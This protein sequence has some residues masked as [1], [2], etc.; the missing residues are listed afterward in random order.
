MRDE[1]IAILTKYF[2]ELTQHQQEQ[3]T[4]LN[5]LYRSWNE[6]I[7]VISRKD[8]N[9]LYVHHV[10]HSLSIAKFIKFRK[11]TNVLDVGTGGGFPGIPLAI[12]FPGVNFFLADSIAKKIKVVEA[13]AT[14]VKLSNVI[15]RQIRV[16]EI[17]QQFDF[18]VSRAVTDFSEIYNWTSRLIL[19]KSVNEKLNGWILLKG[20]D[21]ETEMKSHYYE[22]TPL[23]NYFEK[24]FFKNKCLIYSPLKKP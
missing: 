18:I 4:L 6:K 8:I 17:K 13:V 20:G 14:E 21:V 19:P 22:K 12:Y 15:A 16:E 11:E 1:P 3:F 23:E 10:L 24:D 2:P 9:N 5:E 7:N